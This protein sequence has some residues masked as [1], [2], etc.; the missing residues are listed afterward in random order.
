MSK[1]LA[2]RQLAD[3]AEVSDG[4]VEILGSSESDDGAVL[5]DVS[6]DTSGFETVNGGIHVRDR[7]RFEIVVTDRFP[8]VPPS[9]VTHHR[10]WAGTPHVQWGRVLCL[11]A[12]TSVE[13][14]PSDGMR[15][16][17]ERLV[18][19]LERA[20]AGTL[21]P[22]GQPLHPPVAYA[23][24]EAGVLV[25]RADVGELVPWGDGRP[26]A[27]TSLIYAWCVYDGERL[28][29]SEWLEPEALFERVLADE[30]SDTDEAGQ[31]HVVAA[32]L[33]VSDEIAF[34]YPRKAADLIEGLSELGI[35]RE[36]L[37]SG[38]TIAGAANRII[39]SA[40]ESDQLPVVVLLGTPSRRVSGSGRLAHLS[41]WRFDDL[42][43]QITS[44]LGTAAS[45]SDALSDK[46][47]SLANDWLGFAKVLWMTVHEDRPEVTNRRDADTAAAWL[48]NKRVLV[49]GCGALGAP[50]AE[51]CVRAG[52]ASLTV[53]DHGVVKP[54]LLV[55]QPCGDSDIGRRKTEALAARLTGIRR[56][57]TLTPFTGNVLDM[58][59]GDAD[60][61][62]Y[63]LVIDA[64]ANI[65]VRTAIEAARGRQRDVW[66]PVICGLFGY[67]A[68]RGIGLLSRAGATGGPH[69][70]L[71]RVAI[72]AR[73]HTAAEW[74]DIANDIFPDPPRTDRFFP[75]P[76]CSEPTFVGGATQADALASSLLWAALNELSNDSADQE[77]M[78][79]FAI[80]LPGGKSA[81][82]PSRLSWPDDTVVT[83]TSGGY[84]IRMSVRAL[85]EMRAEVRRGA[86]TRGLGHET[87]GM[88]LGSF[89]DAVGCIYVDL[90]TGPSPDS[91]LSPMYF[92]HGTEG[93]QDV[94]DHHR[95]R[96][97][98][99]VGFV[100]MWHT[101]P[102]GRAHPSEIDTAGMDWLVSPDGA[103]RRALM[104][105]LGGDKADWSAWC[106]DGL[107][108]DLYVEVVDRTAIAEPTTGR[109]HIAPA[110]IASARPGGYY[111]PEPTPA[112]PWWRRL[113]RQG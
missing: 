45:L 85:A 78:V 112:A 28:D 44:L 21:D 8:H 33:F 7:E 51:Q 6:L 32:A 30:V 73:G 2:V 96:T 9:V 64:T 54:G 70:V 49:L 22:D 103:G 89:D 11:Y 55:R 39:S 87:G 108:P 91:V 86:R 37:L 98:R 16:F 81:T 84:E 111:Q 40:D 61:P 42:G 12:A 107:L 46:V 14:N 36:T 60:P 5:L 41:A 47:R 59:T 95:E 92:G 104:V 101:H 71:R 69:D 90:A 35:T 75:E 113:W 63:D 97:A 15:G 93:T 94:V 80:R 82:G 109:G 31:R 99:R 18:L 52:V 53:A 27:A 56:D 74:A 23:S 106:D 29:V 50:I 110:V 72:D 13:W 88:L 48:R 105:I 25:V 58:F 24:A 83:D 65:G 43:K 3:L 38:V 66:P 26:D 19:W 79:A 68:T 1:Y 102:G 76:G 67:D 10:R 77:P 34:E 100:G 62:P 4:A 17:I 20:A 57:L